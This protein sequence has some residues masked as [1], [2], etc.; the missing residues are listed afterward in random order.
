MDALPNYAYSLTSQSFADHQAPPAPLTPKL[1][2][3][4][5]NIKAILNSLNL[6]SPA[7]AGSVPYASYLTAP[8][9]SYFGMYHAQC[10]T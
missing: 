3:K 4:P 6:E 7:D 8:Y 10:S 2:P 1:P 5:G 9:T